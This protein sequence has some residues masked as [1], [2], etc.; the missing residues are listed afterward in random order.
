MSSITASKKWQPP[1]SRFF[2]LLDTQIAST[3][4]VTN[5][6][7]SKPLRHIPQLKHPI[8]KRQVLHIYS[9]TT[10]GSLF[11]AVTH[12]GI[13]TT[14]PEERPRQPRTTR[15]TSARSK[16]SVS[17]A[18]S[19]ASST[20]Q[21]EFQSLCLHLTSIS[22][23][24]FLRRLPLATDLGFSAALAASIFSSSLSSS[25][26]SSRVFT[27]GVRCLSPQKGLVYR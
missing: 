17:R 11:N 4:L 23:R 13:F 9:S 7:S 20:V 24:G 1:L 16:P 3:A 15:P 18:R 27:S 22:T 19:A 25:A 2:L 8:Q 12:N 10:S 26:T 5:W 14:D 6:A 21:L